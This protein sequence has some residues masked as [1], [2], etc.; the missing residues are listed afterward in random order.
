QECRRT[1]RTSRGRPRQVVN[2]RVGRAVSAIHTVIKRRADSIGEAGLAV[3][4]GLAEVARS[5]LR[6]RHVEVQWTRRRMLVHVFVTGPEEEFLAVLVEVKPR[7]YD[8]A[9]N[10][11]STVVIV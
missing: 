1:R 9:A 8:W 2:R 3:D 5:L 6:G 10:V 7:N 11:S 4:R